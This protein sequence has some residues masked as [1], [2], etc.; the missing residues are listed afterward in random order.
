MKWFEIPIIGAVASSGKFDLLFKSEA[1]NDE[2]DFDSY[3]PPN[4]YERCQKEQDIHLI[5][6]PLDDMTDE[7]K[8]DLRKH[9]GMSLS[10]IEGFIIEPS[11]YHRHR[12]YYLMQNWLIKNGF[13]IWDNERVEYKKENS[14]E[15]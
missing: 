12:D 6:R 10:Q 5:A 1:G 3:N 11:A 7:E 9:V 14:N 2:I 15:N 13:W 8:I 4:F